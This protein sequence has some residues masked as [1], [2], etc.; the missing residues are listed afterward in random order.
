M[1]SRPAVHSS[2]SRPVSHDRREGGLWTPWQAAKNHVFYVAARVVLF[3]LRPMPTSWLRAVGAGLARV[4]YLAGGSPRR[5]AL[6]NLERAYPALSA[7]ERRVLAARTYA[8]LGSY[9]GDTVA[10]L[11]HPDRFVPLAFEEGS[12]AVLAE[13]VRGGAGVVFASAH[14]GP[15]E[16]VAGSLVHHGFPLTT[17][18][19]ESYDPRFTCLYERLRVGVG[20][21]SVYR[22]GTSAALGVVRTLRRGGVLGVPMDLRSRVPSVNA[23]F[24]GVIAPT[25][26]GPARIALRTGASVVV[27]TVV[28]A[29]C[30]EGEVS[31]RAVRRSLVLRV[32]RIH[33]ADLRADPA[34]ERQ[35]TERLNDAISSR[36]RAFPEGWVWMHPRWESARG[37]NSAPSRRQSLYTSAVMAGEVRR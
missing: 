20:V 14:L 2:V 28:P 11:L 32:T 30:G 24:L 29:P 35:L 18:A 3:A 7:R 1:P 13:A 10:Q 12:R 9:L 33:T 36:I 34:G 37:E 15:W 23:P 17:L 16:R 19:R 25:P 31:V 22:G 26:V 4:L 8:R 5:V 6:A 21:R 27:G